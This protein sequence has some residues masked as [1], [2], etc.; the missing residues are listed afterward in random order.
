MYPLYKSLNPKP[1]WTPIP[2]LRIPRSFAEAAKECEAAKAKATRFRA[3][4]VYAKFQVHQKYI[5]FFFFAFDFGV[6]LPKLNIGK[7]YC[8]YYGVGL[9]GNQELLNP[10]P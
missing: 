1:I 2:R 3:I 8:Y 5:F 10:K 6:S 7:G 4:R 9:L